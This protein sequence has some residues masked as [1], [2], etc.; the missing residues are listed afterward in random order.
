MSSYTQKRKIGLDND[1]QFIIS[2]SELKIQV[3]LPLLI[4]TYSP[5][6]SSTYNTYVIQT[7]KL[8]NELDLF[9]Q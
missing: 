3:F 7:L 1:N 9:P 4:S 5:T 6:E 8:H 2:S